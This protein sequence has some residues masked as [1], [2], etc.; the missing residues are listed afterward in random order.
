MGRECK[1]P[2]PHDWDRRLVS[3]SA[4]ARR[5]GEFAQACVDGRSLG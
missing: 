1:R 5:G 2:H 4:G 3:L